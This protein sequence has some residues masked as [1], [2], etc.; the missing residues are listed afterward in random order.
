LPPTI[1]SRIVRSVSE[2]NVAPLVP[3]V[4]ASTFTS[5]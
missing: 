5:G 1:T 2:R 3:I 4:T